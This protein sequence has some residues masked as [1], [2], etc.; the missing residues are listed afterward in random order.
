MIF[1]GSTLFDN[2]SEDIISVHI[3]AGSGVISGDFSGWG[4]SCELV[5][6]ASKVTAAMTNYP[7]LLT[8]ATLPSEMLD[9]D[10]P[11]PALDGGGDIRFSSDQEGINLLACEIVTFVTDNNPANGEAEIWVNVPSISSSSNTS[12]WVWYEK[13][14]ETQPAE[15]TPLGSESVWESNYKGV[16]HMHEEVPGTGTTDLYK[17][18]TAN[19]NHGDDYVSATGQNGQ[20]YAGQEFSGNGDSVQIP[21]DPS[22]NLTGPMTI[23]FWIHPTQ[24]TGAYNRVVDKTFTTSYYFGCGNGTNDLTFYLSGNMVIETPNNTISVDTW[25]YAVVT[26]DN[27]GDATL[28]LNGAVIGTGNYTGGIS[29]STN[30][31]YISHSHSTYDFPGFIDEVRIADVARS[32]DWITTQYNNQ[33]DPP[34]FII[35]GTPQTP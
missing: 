4:R 34:T 15:N 12:I 3:G 25:Q 19:L 11:H 14:G 23:S 10:G 7:L 13:A 16:W 31:V 32:V 33:E 22:L 6:Q 21:H 35:E 20:I 30:T 27:S 24:N 29:G 9:A 2:P 18:S 1:D 17:D 26:Y 8:E 28:Y 5:I